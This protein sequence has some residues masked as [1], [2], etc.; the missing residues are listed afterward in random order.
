MCGGPVV[1]GPLGP[2]PVDLT[3]SVRWGKISVAGAENLPE[4]KN[5]GFTPFLQSIAHLSLI[6]RLFSSLIH[7]ILRRIYKL[8]AVCAALRVN[9]RSPL[10]N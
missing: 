4:A 6:P 5:W 1:N 7:V 8:G 10:S 9:Y 2:F 3:A